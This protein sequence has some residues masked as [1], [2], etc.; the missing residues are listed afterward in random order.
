MTWQDAPMSAKHTFAQE[1]D[2]AIRRMR[3][4]PGDY[5]LFV[6]WRNEPHVAE[7]WTTDDDP[8]P[9]TLERVMADYGPRIEREFG[10]TSCLIELDGGPIGYAQFYR[11]GSHAEEVREMGLVLAEDACGID[12]FIGEFELAGR[13]IGSRAV[14]LLTRFLF[15][16][17]GATQVA[18]VTALD[19]HRAQRAYEKAGFRKVG[20][21]LDTDVRGGERVRSWLMT[22]ARPGIMTEP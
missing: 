6:R 7:W 4:D 17:L 14:S 5:A 11:W 8:T 1:G 16:E 22:R 2:L 10:T 13:G 3:D 9:T 15:E 19:N 21:V 20:V 18:I 12:I